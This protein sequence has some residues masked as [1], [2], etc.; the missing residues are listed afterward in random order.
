M[1]LKIKLTAL[2]YE[3]RM[4]ETAFGDLDDYFAL[5][6]ISG[7]AVSAD[8]SRVVTTVS[9]LNEKRTEYVNAIW[10]VDPEGR[11]QARRLTRGAKGES[12]PVFT[13]DGDLLFIAVRPT[14]D[15]EK[16]P[17]ALWSLPAAGGEAVEILA[18]PG[19]VDLVKTARSAAT[20]VVRSPLLPSAH[21]IDDDRRLRELRKD[22]KISAILHSGYP[23]RYWDK[24]LGPGAPHLLRLDPADGSAPVDLTPEPGAA[25][26]DSDFD[27]SSDGRFLVTSWQRPAP[28]ASQRS[29]LVRVDVASGDHTVIADD[30]DADLWSPAISPDGSSVAFIRESHSTPTRAPRI[31]LGCL[32]FGEDDGAQE[33]ATDWDRWPVSVTWSD[34]GDALIVTADDNG[35]APVF[36]IGIRDGGVEALTSDDYAYTDVTHGAGRR[37][38]RTAELVRSATAPGAHRSGRHRDG[39]AVRRASLAARVGH[40]DH[41]GH[42]R[43]RDGAVVAGA[44]G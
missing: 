34:D 30:P 25:L 42:T 17:A 6:R 5:P 7:L 43:R 23:I 19:G 40:R 31:I 9:E 8:G 32:R 38:L 11:G 22:N 26:R 15:D 14:E 18:P 10:E 33:A 1:S 27:V 3:R 2:C 24:D 39:A 37:G 21:S 20:A 12:S 44:P 28:G 4:N 29:V 36:R 41:G 16:P 35:R 13:S